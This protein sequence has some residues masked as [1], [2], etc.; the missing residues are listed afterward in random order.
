MLE[1]FFAHLRR[2]SFGNGEVDQAAAAIDHIR[3]DLIERM[4]GE[5]EICQRLIGDRSQIRHRV[6]QRAIAI[7]DHSTQHSGPFP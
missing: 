1:G 4:R 5:A 2:G 6:E 7:E 3:L